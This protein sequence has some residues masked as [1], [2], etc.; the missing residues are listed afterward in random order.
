MKTGQ[1]FSA[2]D[3]ILNIIKDV[4]FKFTGYVAVYYLGYYEFSLAWLIT[5]LL[6]ILFIKAQWKFLEDVRKFQKISENV[7]MK[8]LIQKVSPAQELISNRKNVEWVN[9]IIQQMWPNLEQFLRN[10]IKSSVEPVINQ[11]SGSVMKAIKFDKLVFGK[12]P[13]KIVGIKVHEQQKLFDDEIIMDVDVEFN[14]NCDIKFIVM[15]NI[16]VEISKISI[17]GLIRVVLKP[18]MK[19]LPLIGGIQ[20][21]FLTPPDIDFDLGGIANVLDAPGISKFIKD[22][23]LEQICNFMVLPNKIINTFTDSVSKKEIKCPDSMGVLRVDLIRAEDLEKKDKRIRGVST[24]D[25]Y[26]TLQGSET[27]IINIFLRTK[28]VL[29]N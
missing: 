20:I 24:P 9:S 29:K 28:V 5:P 23:L 4:V 27:S 7:K 8:E 18:L 17:S 22:I 6:P 2:N 14:S 3:G 12:I 15:K 16:P 25:P 11:N 10:L 26:A 21:Y 13:P 19:D 1:E